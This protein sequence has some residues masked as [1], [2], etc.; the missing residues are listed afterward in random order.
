MSVQVPLE[1]PKRGGGGK[2]KGTGKRKGWRDGGS[3]DPN[4]V[5]TYE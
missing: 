4:I 1:L 2:R 3:N 5:S